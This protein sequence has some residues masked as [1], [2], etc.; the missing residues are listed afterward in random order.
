MFIVA[1]AQCVDTHCT[2]LLRSENWTD[3]LVEKT[4]TSLHLQTRLAIFT[5]K[6][7]RKN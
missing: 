1:P 2:V 3:T 6:K 5:A 4:L 7:C